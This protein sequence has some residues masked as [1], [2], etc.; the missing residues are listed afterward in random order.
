MSFFIDFFTLESV[1]INIKFS[2]SILNFYGKYHHLVCFCF[3]SK[4]KQKLEEKIFLKIKQKII[5]YQVKLKK[6]V[7]VSQHQIWGQRK[8]HYMKFSC[9]PILAQT[10]RERLTCYHKPC[11]CRFLEST[12]RTS[13]VKRNASSIGSNCNSA[14]SIGSDVQLFIGIALFGKHR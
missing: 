14:T 11:K 3:F 13:F 4:R 9:W 1:I 5:N 7:Q 12:D 6:I 2:L 8:I 10:V